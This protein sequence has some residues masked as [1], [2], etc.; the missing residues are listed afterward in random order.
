M[1]CFFASL[2]FFWGPLLKADWQVEKDA[3]VHNSTLQS[4]I[5]T[6]KERLKWKPFSFRLS[7]Y[8]CICISIWWGY[9]YGLSKISNVSPVWK[10]INF[11]VKVL[12]GKEGLK[13][14]NHST[15]LPFPSTDSITFTFLFHM[16]MNGVDG[17]FRSP[18]I[19]VH[20]KLHAFDYVIL[21]HPYYLLCAE[22][23]QLLRTITFDGCGH[24]KLLFIHTF[25][26][27]L[28]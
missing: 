18:Y 17:R 12:D 9:A 7:I 26:S 22:S 23:I 21:L 20:N 15:H 24:P 11:C 27:S 13:T 3:I 19:I 16:S 28:E 1:S 4:R 10:F 6:K 5:S 25:I 8:L 2:R 14:P